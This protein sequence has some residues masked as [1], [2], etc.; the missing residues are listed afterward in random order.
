MI[1]KTPG[2]CGGVACI[3]GTRIPV[4]VLVQAIDAG[5]SAVEVWQDYPRLSTYQWAAAIDYAK[6]N[7]DEIAA[8][9]EANAAA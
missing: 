9:I 1:T 6:G 8:D 3:D 5:A 4:W 2:V 7:A